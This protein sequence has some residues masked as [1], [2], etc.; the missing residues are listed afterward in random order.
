MM[1]ETTNTE[2]D[3]LD[4]LEDNKLFKLAYW[5]KAVSW[6]I[7]VVG[8]LQFIFSVC[9]DYFN[10]FVNPQFELPWAGSL[11]IAEFSS[12]LSIAFYFFVLQAVG[13]I[14]YL[15]IDKKEH[16]QVEKNE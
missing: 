12:L 16:M 1:E 9:G 5:S 3:D 15:L 7:V 10:I 13:E 14:L 11:M 2:T 4:L 8:V 6:V